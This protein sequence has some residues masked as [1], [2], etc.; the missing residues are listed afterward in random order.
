MDVST[1]M[2]V[3]VLLAKVREKVGVTNK[4]RLLYKGRP[5]QMRDVSIERAGLLGEPKAVHFMLSRKHRP[6][7]VV[8]QS[9][10]EAEELSV[11]MAMAAAEAAARPPRR[12]RNGESP[13]P[14]PTSGNSAASV[15]G[16]W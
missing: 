6:P 10:A 16:D 15:G 14:R 1:G 8:E 2:S 11:A 9:R 3:E 7:E 4:G 5:V 12:K 13:P